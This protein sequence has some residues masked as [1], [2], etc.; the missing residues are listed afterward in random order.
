M[1]AEVS[2]PV[3]RQGVMR[4]RKTFG[5]R[6]V[7]MAGLKHKKGFQTP[8]M[9][10]CAKGAEGLGVMRRVRILCCTLAPKTGRWM[11]APWG[12]KHWLFSAVYNRGVGLVPFS[13]DKI[14]SFY[15]SYKIMPWNHLGIQFNHHWGLRE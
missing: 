12:G 4:L 6:S 1:V 2:C 9:Q 8:V 3:I 11:C 5:L 14:S 13:E 15:P 10:C 7:V